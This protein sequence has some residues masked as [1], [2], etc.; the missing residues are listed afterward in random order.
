MSIKEQRLSF[1]D[2]I[3]DFT[4]QTFNTSKGIVTVPT[5]KAIV[6]NLE[7]VYL[8]SPDSGATC[9]GIATIIDENCNGGRFAYY[10]ANNTSLT[11]GTGNQQMQPRE[12][13]LCELP[14]SYWDA[15]DG[16]NGEYRKKFEL[17]LD[18]IESSK[19]NIIFFEDI[20]TPNPLYKDESIAPLGATGGDS[21]KC[22]STSIVDPKVNHWGIEI[23]ILKQI[24][25]KLNLSALSVDVN[26]FS[27]EEGLCL[28]YEEGYSVKANPGVAQYSRHVFNHQGGIVALPHKGLFRVE[29]LADG[30]GLVVQEENSIYNEL[31][32]PETKSHLD[33]TSLPSVSGTWQE[34]SN[35]TIEDN[36][37][38]LTANNSQEY[39][40]LP[41][42]TGA[43]DEGS[44]I[45]ID[46]D[47]ISEGST[48]SIIVDFGASSFRQELKVTSQGN[49]VLFEL[50]SN[51]AK[52]LRSSHS[53]FP[54]EPFRVRLTLKQLEDNW[55]ESYV[56]LNG[57]ER[58][59][60]YDK[61]I[62]AGN[63]NGITNEFFIGIED[64]NSTD[65]I[66]KLSQVKCYANDAFAPSFPSAQ[67]AVI[68]TIVVGSELSNTPIGLIGC[69]LDTLIG[70]RR[71]GRPV[72]SGEVNQIFDLLD[73]AIVYLNTTLDQ[74][75]S[76][77]NNFLSNSNIK[78]PPNAPS[79]F[80][81]DYIETTETTNEFKISDIKA[82]DTTAQYLL[83]ISEQA[84]NITNT[85]NNS[86]GSGLG[87][88]ET[89][90]DKVYYLYALRKSNDINNSLYVV[91]E[92]N[93]KA[94]DDPT[95]AFP[96]DYTVW[97]QVPTCL[98]VV[99]G[100]IVSFLH[101]NNKYTFK[102]RQ[103]LGG[104]A[105]NDWSAYFNTTVLQYG[106]SRNS[107]T[108]IDLSSILPSYTR[109][110]GLIAQTRRHNVATS[111]GS[112]SS[113]NE[114]DTAII[115]SKG[116]TSSFLDSVEI[117]ENYTNYVGGGAIG[118]APYVGTHYE[119]GN[120]TYPNLTL[121]ELGFYYYTE[122][123]NKSQ[124][125]FDIQLSL[126]LDSFEFPT[127]EYL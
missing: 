115:S 103:N 68:G 102:N 19:V 89:L 88:G 123:A 6:R 16:N 42:S 61:N 43:P 5:R 95:S 81:V 2:Q 72:Y 37:I 67:G 113:A 105:S 87:I 92:L 50:G 9:Q 83:N 124:G 110:I 70:N 78:L 109:D 119:T 65:K 12:V 120:I 85:A 7:Y 75:L 96:T 10:S 66:L 100:Q 58:P 33:G 21:G 55:A 62:N 71:E 47:K 34:S 35:T 80:K 17:T 3:S 40:K 28:E 13:W 23:A 56:Y 8:P 31:Y 20:R 125:Y 46:I 39:I 86:G 73:D 117:K 57:A 49:A 11:V 30:S 18:D 94:G 106:L 44:F 77:V 84:V 38:K 116:V 1:I 127:S 104:K 64:S 27:V 126:A 60:L 97:R 122:Y 52:S 24:I 79:Y 4:N 54:N 53:S 101:K 14:N 26:S 112:T 25:G 121:E 111:A 45:D 63:V 48:A 22:I 93:S 98:I 41:N 51:N 91:S 108:N 107:W 90:T 118:G 29:A 32:N 36:L 59:I 74:A 99:A 69:D 15:L 114:I 82:L 76:D